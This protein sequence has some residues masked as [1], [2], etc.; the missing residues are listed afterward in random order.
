MIRTG[1]RV[2]ALAAIAAL[3]AAGASAGS[4]LRVECEKPGTLRLVRYEDA[5]ARLYCAGRVLVRIGV[6]Y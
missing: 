1:L 2:C 3:G 6:P 5:S 4:A